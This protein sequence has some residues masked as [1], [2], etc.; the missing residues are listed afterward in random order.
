MVE[1]VFDSDS[2]GNIHSFYSNENKL[3]YLFAVSIWCRVIFWSDCNFHRLRLSTLDDTHFRCIYF[4]IYGEFI[5]FT[6]ESDVG[7]IKNN[8]NL[9][10]LFGHF[11]Y[12]TYLR[13]RKLKLENGLPLNSVN[14]DENGNNNIVNLKANM[15]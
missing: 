3:K 4:H 15:L 10:L 7:L 2:T 9:Q 5:K 13:D 1:K 11:Y 6:E 12:V 8:S 14:I